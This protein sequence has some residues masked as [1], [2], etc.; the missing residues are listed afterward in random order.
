[1]P[2]LP[3]GS[4][5]FSLTVY[6]P[7][8]QPPVGDA[9]STL[10][11]LPTTTGEPPGAV[12]DHSSAAGSVSSPVSGSL[13]VPLSATESNGDTRSAGR[14]GVSI[15]AVGGFGSETTGISLTGLGVVRV[16]PSLSAALRVPP[17][18]AR[19]ASKF[20]SN[21]ALAPARASGRTPTATGSTL[22]SGH[23]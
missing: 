21:E 10:P 3:A 11:P 15:A 13:P 14:P 4:V 1:M 6:V 5:T 2:V 23:V 17:A 18:H 7:G 12:S 8:A 9:R 22:P 16:K 20:R 19:A